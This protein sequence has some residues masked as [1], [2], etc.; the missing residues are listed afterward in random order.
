MGEDVAQIVAR[1]EQVAPGWGA[2]LALTRRELVRLT[3]Q[4]SRVAV[5]IGTPVVIWLMLASGFGEVVRVGGD[6]AA[7]AAQG[8]GYA[9]YLAPGMASMVVVLS[10]IFAAMSLIEDADAGFLQSALV[11]PAPRWS[12][13]G[14]KIVGG[15]LIGWA[16]A[17]L[18]VPAVVILGASAP[19]WGV[20]AALVALLLMS[21]G[22]TGLCLA[23]A[24]RVS[25]AQ[26]FHGVMNI[27]LM[28]MW[29]LSGAVFP[30]D[31]ASGWLRMVMMVNPLTWATTAV[32]VSLVGG[33]GAWLAWGLTVAFAVAGVGWAWVVMRGRRKLR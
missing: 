22:L 10:S 13:I 12:L 21:V 7:G 25:S 20:A 27:V 14:A 4:P 2:M 28:P 11:S 15:G 18:L 17:A 3:R 19:L 6:G 5:A 23:L 30:L 9:M 1:R 31:G 33:S 24:W 8:G 29:V 16:Q 32:R 26:G